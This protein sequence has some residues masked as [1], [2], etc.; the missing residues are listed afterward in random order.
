MYTNVGKAVCWVW[1][2]TAN[3]PRPN[4]G[5]AGVTAGFLR[6]LLYGLICFFIEKSCQIQSI[7]RMSSGFLFSEW[8][9]M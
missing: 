9:V 4:A 7:G 1:K 6:W 3:G 8:L 2:Y 5:V